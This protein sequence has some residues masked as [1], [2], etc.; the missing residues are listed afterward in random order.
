MKYIV[1][2]FILLSLIGCKQIP[3]SENEIK[4]EIINTDNSEYISD[5]INESESSESYNDDGSLRYLWY[6]LRLPKVNI[7]PKID[8][9]IEDKINELF[10][11][12]SKKEIE[13]GRASFDAN[14][15]VVENDGLLSLLVVRHTGFDVTGYTYYTAVIDVNEKKI[16][17]FDETAKMLGYNGDFLLDGMESYDKEYFYVN[18]KGELI[19]IIYEYNEGYE[20]DLPSWYNT[21]TKEKI[22]LYVPS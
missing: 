5:L 14:Y 9:I 3:S 13:E 18:E 12:P 8:S 15:K 1:I 16:L 19:I 6:T 7:S 20:A 10:Y 4:E 22:S 11:L 17:T 2:V 21:A